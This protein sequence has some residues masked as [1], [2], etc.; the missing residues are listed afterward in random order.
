[1]SRIQIIVS[2]D[3]LIKTYMLQHGYTFMAMSED[4]NCMEFIQKEN[5]GNLPRATIS[6]NS[7]TKEL[8]I[9]LFPMPIEQN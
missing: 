1:M 5:S 2:L 7:D 3:E 4:A 8:T 6:W 9:L